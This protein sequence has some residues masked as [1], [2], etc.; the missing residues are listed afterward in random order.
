MLNIV[1]VYGS[2]YV[3]GSIVHQLSQLKNLA[4]IG[5]SRESEDAMQMIGAMRPHVVIIDAEL[6]DGLGLEVLQRTKQLE[7]P[8]VIFMTAVSSYSQYRR[9]C[10]RHGADYYFQLPDE[11]ESLVNTLSHLASLFSTGDKETKPETENQ[12]KNQ[13]SNGKFQ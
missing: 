1:V 12:K 4:I 8:T 11:I 3:G 5:Q 7:L 2:L 6:K 13:M 10:M 9:E